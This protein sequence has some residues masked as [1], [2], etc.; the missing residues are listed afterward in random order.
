MKIEEIREKLRQ[1]DNERARIRV[2]E[3]LSNILTM[4]GREEPVV[5]LSSTG[6]I[7]AWFK[8]D[9]RLSGEQPVRDIT[10]TSDERIELI[11]WLKQTAWSRSKLI[12]EKESELTGHLEDVKDT[13]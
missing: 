1:I 12:A 3:N 13:P 11:N 2:L 8:R 5:H 6:R 4:R 7:R 9:D 10:L